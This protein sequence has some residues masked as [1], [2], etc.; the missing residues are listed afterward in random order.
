MIHLRQILLVFS[1]VSGVALLPSCIFDQNGSKQKKTGLVIVNVLNKELYEDCHI[2]GSLSVP[3]EQ[4][5]QYAQAHV[6]KDAEIVIYC[7][8]YM[9][10]ASGAACRK[11]QA[12]GF[13]N[14]CAYEA[15]TAEWY[16]QGLPT[17]GPAKSS[18]LNH[19]LEQPTHD[20]T[21]ICIITTQELS[22]KM[23]LEKKI[24]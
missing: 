3:F 8:N 7:S 22:Q 16:Q 18:Y 6:D 10:S 21:D 15:G 1:I 24:E 11:L 19:K 2:V 17:Q 12:L 9:C 14:V 23:K 13:K 5:E 20:E 4:V